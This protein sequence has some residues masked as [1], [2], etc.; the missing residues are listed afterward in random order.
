M[1]SLLAREPARVLRDFDSEI[2]GDLGVPPGGNW[3][4]RDLTRSIGFGHMKGMARTHGYVGDVLTVLKDNRPQEAAVL[5]VQLMKAVHQVYLDRGD[6]SNAVLYMPTPDLYARRDF[7][8][9]E[10]EAETISAYRRARADLHRLEEQLMAG[11]PAEEP[12]LS[13]GPFSA[14]ASSHAPYPKVKATPKPKPK[15]KPK[16]KAETVPQ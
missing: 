4:Y 3:S 5:L 16:A 8:G 10:R 15:G 7:G 6:W 1:H 9:S 11:A 12:L 2:V 13:T 14:G